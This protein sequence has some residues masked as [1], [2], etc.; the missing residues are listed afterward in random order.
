[1][2]PL[3]ALTF[4]IS[5][6]ILLYSIC[7]LVWERTRINYCFIMDLNAKR[8]KKQ[9]ILKMSS[10][11]ILFFFLVLNIYLVSI[12]FIYT[13]IAILKKSIVVFTSHT[14]RCSVRGE[15]FEGEI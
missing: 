13:R 4:L 7:V 10:V 12:F 15:E 8:S 2:F 14:V 9:E 3:F 6:H 5:L 1:M 11:L